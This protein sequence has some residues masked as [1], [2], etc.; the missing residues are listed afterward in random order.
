MAQHLKSKRRRKYT[1]ESLKDAI[2]A[3]ANGM[4]VRKAS[5]TFRVP[6]M[7]IVR[8][9]KSLTAQKIRRKTKLDTTEEA[10]LV[11]MLKQRIPDE[12]T[13]SLF[14]CGSNKLRQSEGY[15][16]DPAAIINFDES[17]FMLG[18]EKEKVCAARGMKH[19]PSY[20][21]GTTRDRVSTLVCGDAAGKIYKPLVLF[22]GIMHL[23]SMFDNTDGKLYNA[24]NGSGVMD[25]DLIT[26]YF[27][28]VI[29]PDAPQKMTRNTFA[30]HLAL[31]CTSE[32][33]RFSFEFK[34]PLKSGFKNTSIFPFSPETKTLETADEASKK[35]G[36]PKTVQIELPVAVKERTRSKSAK[37]DLPVASKKGRSK[38]VKN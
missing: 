11:D 4:S 20:T 36:R 7:T 29:L 17:G 26:D 37:A 28:K 38:K 32:A 12:Q 6:Q 16:S 31:L 5:L 2:R 19:V 14:F 25:C 8:Y 22:D 35:R 9:E 13:R 34:A 15:L 10:S 18:F 24:V 33:S 30:G 21:D 3:V 23:E 1:V 27:R